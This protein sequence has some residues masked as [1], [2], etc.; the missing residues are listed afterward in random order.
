KIAKVMGPERVAKT[1]RKFGFGTS[2]FGMGF[3]GEAHGWV[4][5]W[6]K[7]RDIRFA[8]IAF[9]QGFMATGPELVSAFAALANGGRLVKPYIVERIEGPDGKVKKSFSAQTLGTSV[10]AKTAKRVRKILYRTVEEA[11]VK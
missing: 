7:W 4:T 3:P 8:N 9:G 10:S 6:K 1:L 2:K 5:D 11:A